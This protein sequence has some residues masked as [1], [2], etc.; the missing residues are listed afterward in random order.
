MH[1]RASVRMHLGLTT[2]HSSDPAT[3]PVVSPCPAITQRV[4]LRA[5]PQLGG[6]VLVDYLGV[7]VPGI[8]RAIDGD[9]RQLEVLTEDGATLTFALNRATATFT[10]G[11]GQTAPRLR[12]AAAHR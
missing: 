4:P 11:G 7:T 12:F 6:S 9:G 8:V 5:N 3:N 10:V 1:F 2:G